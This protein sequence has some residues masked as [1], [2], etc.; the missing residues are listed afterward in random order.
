M[1]GKNSLFKRGDFTEDPTDAKKRLRQNDQKLEKE[2][3][4]LAQQPR[5]QKYDVWEQHRKQNADNT[6]I[7]D[8]VSNMVEEVRGTM[9]EDN[10]I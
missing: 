7:H 5:D 9:D 4:V 3:E 8:F 10:I 6:V 2:A 1:L